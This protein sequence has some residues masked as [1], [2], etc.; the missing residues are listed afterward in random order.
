MKKIIALVL[1]LGMVF[2]L[3]ACVGDKGEAKAL[4][5][6]LAS[7]PDTIDPALNSAVDG[8]TLIIHAF[9]GLAGYRQNDKGELEL[10]ADCAK[11]L[12]EPTV[13]ED[14]KCTYVYE[15]KDG[16]K[17]S[18]GSDLT[19]QD[20]VYAWNRAASAALGADYGYMFEVV[21]GYDKIS[22]MKE[23]KDANGNVVKD[24]EGNP[25]MEPEFPDAKLNISASDDGKTLT[26][27]TTGKIP[28]WNEL[29]AF[30][31]YM[32]V[33]S[34]VVKDE[35]WAT[36][37]DTYIG[38]GPYVLSEWEHNS[39]IVYKKNENY[40]N[41][42]A[43]TMDSIVFYLSDDANNMLANFK[44]GDWLF[45]DDVPTAEITNLKKDYSNEFVVAGQIG[46][47]YVNFNINA[48]LLPA[49]STLKGNEAEAAQAEIRRAIGLMFDRNYIVNDIA[50]GGQLPASSFVAAGMTEPDGS[51]FYKNSGS[52]DKFDGYWNVSADAYKSNC[53]EAIA[54]LKKYYKFDE[55]T[56]KFTNFPTLEYLYNTNEGHKA[57]GEYLQS[58]L[59]QYGIKVN[60]V[61]QEWNTFLNTRKAGDFTFARN[62]WVADYNDPI[63]FL[64]MWISA[65]GNNDAQFGRD[66][67]KDITLYSLDLTPYGINYK[68]ENTT[69]AKTYDVLISEIKKCDNAEN[70][71]KMM[72]LAED[73][74][75]QTGVICPLYFYTDLYMINSNVKGFFS[76]P[77][78]YK[79]FMY[80]TIEA[81]K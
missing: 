39:K 4:S 52:N 15:L 6:C 20:F 21:D 25:K 13:G 27:V 81:D 49:D 57:I 18:D 32:P 38:N 64:D 51:E 40:H 48:N 35:S 50:Q 79:Y 16:L 9:S 2:S 75:M 59:A 69:W 26:V 12:V 30:P 78:G 72:H 56:G 28:Y 31:T 63:C 7:E 19:A 54:T 14:G 67:H 5:V 29:L 46:T 61:N 74:L 43:V 8:A 70:R 34:D 76:S 24:E 44:K 45:I 37:P 17:W 36:K 73:L 47:Y 22:A 3:A 80:T 11:E 65:S 42:D 10:Y 23:V 68:V 71:F 1:A 60:M 33:K 77:L 62:G 53:D 58:A 66:N 55:A 41:A